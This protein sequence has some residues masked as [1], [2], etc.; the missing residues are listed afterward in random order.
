MGCSQALYI[1]SQ[2]TIPLWAGCLIVS[3]TAFG[4]LLLE[5]KGARWLEVIFGSSITVLAVS[6]AV[7]PSS[8]QCWVGGGLW[9]A[10]AGGGWRVVGAG[11]GL[12]AP[13]HPAGHLHGD[14][15]LGKGS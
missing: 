5:R 6:M 13:H 2:G 14:G 8:W 3:L 11:G 12:W 15:S 7:S 4:L 10:G 9:V 1:L